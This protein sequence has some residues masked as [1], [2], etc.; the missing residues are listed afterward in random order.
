MSVRKHVLC[1][2]ICILATCGQAFGWGPDGHHTVGAIADRMIAGTNAEK[3]VRSIIGDITLQDASVWADCAKSVGHGCQYQRP[4]DRYK[5]CIVLEAAGE[6]ASM[7]DFVCRNS[8]HGEYHYTDIAYQQGRYDAKFVGAR[9]DDVVHA[10]AAAIRVLKG[11][12]P[13][14]PFDFDKHQALMLLAHYVGDMHQPLHA[15]AVYLTANGKPINPKVYDKRTDTEGGNLLVVNSDKMHA[16]WDDVPAALTVSHIE[17]LMGQAERVPRTAGQCLT[18]PAK[19]AGDTVKQS[20]KAFAGLT[21]GEQENGHWSVTLPPTYHA[22]MADVKQ[23]QIV[24]A[25]AHLAQL[26]KAIWP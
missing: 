24:K 6:K 19:W 21:Y 14:K 2:A 3:Q 18:W 7:E 9:K 17:D 5:E 26:L 13:P 8:Q 22:T 20:K 23:A 11:K 15:G 12:K 4:D 25:G 1:Y 10:A 16:M